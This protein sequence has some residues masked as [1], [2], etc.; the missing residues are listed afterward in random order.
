[1]LK[2]E[3]SPYVSAA[4]MVNKFQSRTRDLD[5]FQNR[6]LSHVSYRIQEFSFTV[7]CELALPIFYKQM[8]FCNYRLNEVH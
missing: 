1:M 7:K 6:S 3:V 8:S 5:I 2:Q 4:E